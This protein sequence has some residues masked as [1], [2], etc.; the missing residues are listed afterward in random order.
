MSAISVLVPSPVPS[1]ACREVS[2]LVSTEFAESNFILAKT[3]GLKVNASKPRNNGALS[4]ETKQLV[5][6]FHKSKCE[7]V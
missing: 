4:E 2:P 3:A 6:A 7:A 5:N 1:R